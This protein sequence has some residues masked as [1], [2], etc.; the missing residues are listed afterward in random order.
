MLERM[1]RGE[2]TPIDLETVASVQDNIIGNC[3]CVLG[4]S[5]AMPVGSMVKKFREEFMEAIEHG[6]PGASL[7]APSG[8]PAIVPPGARTRPMPARAGAV[9]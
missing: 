8:E 2:A 9:A 6:V 1:I 5:M 7:G 3:L 4:D